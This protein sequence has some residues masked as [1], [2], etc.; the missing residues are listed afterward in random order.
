MGGGENS[1]Y[2]CSLG[3]WALKREKRGIN[4]AEHPGLPVQTLVRP[5]NRG[6]QKFFLTACKFGS[7]N[8]DK[9]KG[10]FLTHPIS[11]SSD[12]RNSSRFRFPHL[13]VMVGLWGNF[14]LVYFPKFSLVI[15]KMI[16]TRLC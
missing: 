15:I 14:P 12:W 11:E 5:G 6:K 4:L 16:K 7:I 1:F 10:D 8:H 3:T 2:N 13:I 9:S